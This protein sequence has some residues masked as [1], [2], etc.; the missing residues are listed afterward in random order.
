MPRAEPSDSNRPPAQ[1]C[2]PLLKIDQEPTLKDEVA[3][4]GAALMARRVRGVAVAINIFL[5]FMVTHLPSWVLEHFLIL[6]GEGML[7][8]WIDELE[9]LFECE[10]WSLITIFLVDFYGVI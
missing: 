1:A 2:A 7:F 4:V 10:L 3:S 8:Q 9:T 6:L 5:I